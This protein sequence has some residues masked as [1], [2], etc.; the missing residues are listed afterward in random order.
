GRSRPSPPHR[1]RVCGGRRRQSNRAPSGSLAL[2]AVLFHASE[3]TDRHDGGRVT[4]PDP[5][6]ARARLGGGLPDIYRLAAIGDRIDLERAPVTL[7]ILLENVLR[8][9]G[10]GIVEAADVETLASW[11]AGVAAEAEVPF[12]PAP[13]LL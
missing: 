4:Q 13:V 10:R 1:V 11:R 2:R 5:F 12:M 8:H 7:K 9:A 6:G 3:C